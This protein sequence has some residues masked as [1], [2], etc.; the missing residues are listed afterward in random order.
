[1]NSSNMDDRTVLITQEPHQ[2]NPVLTQ[3]MNAPKF[4]Q[5]QDRMV[6]AARIKPEEYNFAGNNPLISAASSLLCIT[7]D[8]KK[9]SYQDIELLKPKLVEELKSFE[10]QAL[11]SGVESNYVALSRYLLCSFVD[12]VI[13][14]TPWGSESHWASQSMLSSFHNETYGGEKFF[15]L[16]EKLS[17]NPAKYLDLLE[18]MYLCLSLGFEGKYRVLSRGLVELDAIRDSLYRQI[19]SLRRDEKSSL[20][21]N[22]EPK[23][24]QRHKLTRQTSWVGIICVVTISL[25]AIYGGFYYVLNQQSEL[26]IDAFQQI[27]L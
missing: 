17:R 18:L 27:E 21:P 26:V 13:V 2:I 3:N 25:C 6:Y 22:W 24:V 5:L 7:C 9:E 12:E 20:S 23:Q 19:R 11:N 15:L 16:L 8:L 4:D 1:M 14:T 10:F